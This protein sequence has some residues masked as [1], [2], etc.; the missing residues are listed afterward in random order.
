MLFLGHFSVQSV[1]T[2]PQPWH[3]LFTLLGEAERPEA[4]LRQFRRLLRRL[5]RQTELFRPACRVYLIDCLE[6]RRLPRGGL[7]GHFR[8]YL[9]PA[10]VALDLALPEVSERHCVAYLPLASEGEEGTL[11]PF[12]VCK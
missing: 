11:E 1:P 10:P 5:H 4:A 6:V 3:G 12:M 2:D 9:A 8:A 7:L